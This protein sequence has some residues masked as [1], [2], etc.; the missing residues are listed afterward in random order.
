MEI[1]LVQLSLFYYFEL[2]FRAAVVTWSPALMVLVLFRLPV[3]LFSTRDRSVM[4][5]VIAGYTLAFLVVPVPVGFVLYDALLFVGALLL[6]LILIF[7]E[8]DAAR[9]TGGHV[10]RQASRP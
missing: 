3:R 10:E 7:A 6:A 1:D 4:R 2:F 5:C 8:F 9:V